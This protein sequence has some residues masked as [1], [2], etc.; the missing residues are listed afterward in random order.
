MESF[1]FEDFE[2]SEEIKK[3]VKDM[4]FETASY[5]QEKTI[6]L[7]LEGRD[8]IGQSQTGTGKTAAFGIPTVEMIDIEND[9]IQSLVLCPTRELAIQIADELKKLSKYKKGIKVLPVYGGQP[10]DRQLKELKK[11]PQIII[12]TPGR[13][14]DHIERG[15]IK[16]NFVKSVVLDE[17]DEMLD[18]GFREDIEFILKRM[19]SKRQTILFSATMP[20]PMLNMTKRYQKNPEYIKASKKELT[21]EKIEQY[22]VETRERQKIEVLCRLLD[23]YNPRISLVFVNMK[24]KVEEVVTNLQLRGY[25]ADGLQGDMCQEQRDLVM[26]RF[27]NGELDVLVATDVAARGIDVSDVD[28]VFNYDIPQDLD[29]YVHRIGRTGRAGRKGRAFTFVTRKELGKLKEIEN[30][31]KAKIEV[32]K[33]P[34]MIDIEKIKSD[35]LMDNIKEAINDDSTNKYDRVVDKLVEEDYEALDIAKALINMYC[36][37]K[38]KSSLF[39]DLDLS[40]TGARDGMVK[41]FMNIGRDKEVGPKDIVSTVSKEVGIDRDSIGSIRIFDNFSFIEVPKEVAEE[42]VFIMRN[43]EIKGN[44]INVEPAKRK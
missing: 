19:P 32:H 25:L 17:A 24:R 21:V 20:K 35:K 14:K 31:S 30:Y 33:I 36:G 26:S 11:K 29:Y 42:F 28:V 2:I 34:S 18:M 43:R 4:G 16:L 6:P 37:V 5:I 22:Y 3:A 15:T 44:R 23:K 38:R 7:L 41:L 10:I 1:R 39:D 13:T 27:R 9:N 8:V 40:N 12:G